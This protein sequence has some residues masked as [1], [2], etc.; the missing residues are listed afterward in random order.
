MNKKH[1]KFLRQMFFVYLY[2]IFSTIYTLI[3]R[4]GKFGHIWYIMSYHFCHSLNSV[5]LHFG[6][7]FTHRQ[8]K[9]GHFDAA[10]IQ[11]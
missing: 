10:Y 4:K 1:I 2:Q 11:Q 8:L 7:R 5:Q 3:F 9:K 6:A